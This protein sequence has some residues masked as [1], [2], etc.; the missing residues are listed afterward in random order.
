MKPGAKLSHIK[1]RVG[2]RSAGLASLV[3]LGL[4]ALALAAMALF[5]NS[6]PSLNPA[7]QVLHQASFLLD[8]S[9]LPPPS[10]AK[11]QSQTLP[12]NWQLS[13]PGQIGTAWYRIEFVLTDKQ[14]NLS[15]LYVPRLSMAGA[16]FVNGEPVGGVAIDKSSITRQ[17]YRPQLYT[18][19]AKLLKSGVNVIHI[20]LS[21]LTHPKSGLSELYFGPVDAV[22]SLWEQRYFW[23]VTSVQITSALTLGLST[24]ALLAWC[25]RRWNTAYGYFGASALL[26]AVRDTHVLFTE[27]PVSPALWEV[28]VATSIIWVL[29]LIFMFVLRF[30]GQRLPV[31]ER[32]LGLFAL[33]APLSL[34]MADESELRLVIAAC[35]S[36]LLL[37]GAYVIKLLVDVARR[38]RN[39]DAVLL[40]L[41]SLAVYALGAHDWFTQRDVLGFSQP[42]NLHFGGPILFIAVAWNMFKRFTTAQA[43]A[44]EMTRSLERRVQQKN[45]ELELSFERMR[46]AESARLLVLERER[47]MRDMHDGVGSQLMAAHQLAKQGM[48]QADELTTVLGECLDDLRLVIDSLEP[49]D[50]DLLN[51][52][53]NLRYRLSDRFVRQGIELNW[54][55]EDLPPLGRLAPCDILQILRIVQEAF[56]NVLKHA[57]ASGVWFSASISADRSQVHLS[58]RD[59]GRGIAI[60]NAQPLRG[61]RGLANMQHRATAVGG[62]LTVASEGQGTVVSL[63]LPLVAPALADWHS[64]PRKT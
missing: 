50:G 49:T 39:V 26:W 62:A 13:R 61:G 46:V 57:R 2:A 59:N 14:L 24:L 36:V 44:D 9:E 12:D 37:M 27:T 33:I 63:T 41:A 21:T 64:S 42:Y 15:A 56:A 32:L 8:E 23:Q 48:L 6:K 3:L 11:W 16:A 60:D 31:A 55:I 35:N 45:V 18:V 29:A 30:A 54:E 52:I 17:W 34:W 1:P 19:P 40:L 4:F 7:T 25:L 51:V 5:E 53:G 38:E 10:H 47:I 43:E 20:R 28:G 58:V 22:T